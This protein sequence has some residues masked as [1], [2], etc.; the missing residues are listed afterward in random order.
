ML[1]LIGLG[2]VDDDV[3]LRGIDAMKKSDEIFCE[4]YT[5]KWMGNLKKL[6]ERIGKKIRVLSREEVESD[7]VTKEA[8]SKNVALLVSGDPLTATTHFEIV[9]QSKQKG[10]KCEVVHAPSIYTAVATT[11]LQLYKFG[12]STTLVFP[13]ENFSPTS[14]YDV[15]EMNRQIGLHTLILLDIKEDKQMSAH[16]G[17]LL[18]LEMEKSLG[19]NLLSEDTR[20]VACCRIGSSNKVI[21]YGS[22]SE[23][24]KDKSIDQ[25]PAVI[26]IPGELNFK[27]E[28]A[29]MLW[30]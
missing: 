16:A 15:I 1:Y 9:F 17:I 24:L 26:V 27:E 20:A 25:S 10:I 8:E 21:R 22:F 7:F 14:P 30:K 11:G 2:L 13:Q 19:R 6:E 12:R 4:F 23:L 28:E 18:L 5:N 29:L 3:A